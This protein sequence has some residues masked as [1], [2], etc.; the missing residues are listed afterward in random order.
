[1]TPLRTDEAAHIDR[2]CSA[3][4]RHLL[5]ARRMHIAI[6]GSDLLSRR[7]PFL[8]SGDHDGPEHTDGGSATLPARRRWVS[9]RDE[10]R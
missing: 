10:S 2:V 6:S 3:R 4:H 8:L 9:Q 7:R 5:P 1:V